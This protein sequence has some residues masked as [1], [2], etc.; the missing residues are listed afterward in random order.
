MVPYTSHGS[1]VLLYSF[2]YLRELSKSVPIK[3]SHFNNYR[4]FNE[5][6]GHTI[7][8]QFHA[9]GYLDY[10]WFSSI[11]KNIAMITLA[12]VTEHMS[13]YIDIDRIDS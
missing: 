2:T 11:T 5:W 1:T 10:F 6:H 3:L 12:C 9:S 7:F 13:E 8:G 4:A